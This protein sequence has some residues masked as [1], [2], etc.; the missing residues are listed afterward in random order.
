MNARGNRLLHGFGDNLSSIRRILLD[1]SFDAAIVGF[2]KRGH[3]IPL[4]DDIAVADWSAGN[5]LGLVEA[6]SDT[7]S[8][9]FFEQLFYFWQGSG[10]GSLV[11]DVGFIH[12]IDRWSGRRMNALDRTSTNGDTGTE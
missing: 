9:V 12:R 10:I 8:T 2:L 11:F 3:V 4:D 7:L 6:A 1:P 5:R